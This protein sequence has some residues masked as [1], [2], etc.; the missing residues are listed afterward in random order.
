MVDILTGVKAYQKAANDL[1]LKSLLYPENNVAKIPGPLPIST[2]TAAIRNNFSIT[3]N[4]NGKFLL[5]IVPFN[6]CGKLY[7]DNTVDGKGNGVAIDLNFDQNNDIVD[8]FRLVSASVIVKY[9]GNFNQMSGVFVI[10][11]TSNIKSGNNGSGFTDYLNF[12][13]I[14][15]LK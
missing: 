10:A 6:S 11:T 1:Y 7:Q 9:Y 5:I 12:D 15:D 4:I 14:E 8:Q 2:A 13:N 3:P